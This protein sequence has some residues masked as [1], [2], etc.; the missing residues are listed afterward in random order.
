M[1]TRCNVIIKDKHN[2]QVF[3]RHS[4]GYPSGVEKSLKTFLSWVDAD[5]FGGNGK[6]RNN[7]Y[8][9][10]GWLVIIGAI[11]YQT[12]HPDSFAGWNEKSWYAKEPETYP[13]PNDW[14]VGA[15]E[16]CSGLTGWIEYLYIIDLENRELLVCPNFSEAENLDD[17]FNTDW[18]SSCI[19]F[20]EFS[21][22]TE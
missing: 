17:F 10:A 22:D 9:S 3:Y 7:V 18:E 11:E 5:R 13:E 19:P 2:Y 16:P 15:Y 4:D 21:E 12:V 1:S 14:K 8:Q 6:I 20:D